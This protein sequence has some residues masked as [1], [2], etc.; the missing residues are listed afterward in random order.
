[1][2]NAHKSIAIYCQSISLMLTAKKIADQ[3]GFEWM[4]TPPENQEF[5]L[6]YSEQG[7]MLHH[8]TEHKSKPLLLDF[9]QGKSLYRRLKGGG[10]NQAI[11]RAIGIK[12]Q[13]RP[14]VIDAT[15]GLAQ[16]SFVLASLGC[17]VYLIER[18][19]IIAALL[20]DA[21]NRASLDNE[22]A[23]IIARMHL[24]YGDAKALI[25]TLPSADV[26]YLDPMFPHE[27]KSALAK[28]GM[29]VLQALL[30]ESDEDILLD[31]AINHA[32]RVVVKRP[33]TGPFLNDKQ[34]SFQMIGS[35]NRFDLYLR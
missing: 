2:S 15:A 1:M 28:K 10:K 32:K 31:I 34:P 6:E 8:I 12:S 33:K 21:L 14:V 20:Q 19:P 11:A 24:Q 22:T 26:I 9:T 3:F 29:Q 18:S 35:S 27:K 5:Y 7:L 17:E 4:A 16:D 23:G 30:G 13:Y 25:P